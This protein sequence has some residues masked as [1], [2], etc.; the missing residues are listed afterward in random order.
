[1]SHLWKIRMIILRCLP[2]RVE[3]GWG[4]LEGG[5]ELIMESWWTRNW[6]WC[7]LVWWD[8]MGRI[9]RWTGSWWWWGLGSD[10]GG[11]L[12]DD[13]ELETNEAVTRLDFRFQLLDWKKKELWTAK[14][15]EM[16]SAETSL[17]S[18]QAGIFGH[19]GLSRF[20]WSTKERSGYKDFSFDIDLNTHLEFSY[21][22]D[23]CILRSTLNIQPSKMLD[24]KREEFISCR[25][26]LYS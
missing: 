24:R 15:Q 17:K 2:R 6:W 8:N 25:L 16:E 10:D 3:W 21:I 22:F 18:I 9:R 4:T 7:R 11:L 20:V 1:M 19:L 12:A 5:L 13:G 23:G 26:S 14:W